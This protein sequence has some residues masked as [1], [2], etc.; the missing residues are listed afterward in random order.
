LKKEKGSERITKIFVAL[1]I[2]I[3]SGLI[4]YLL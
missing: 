4:G 3:V 2:A 1:I